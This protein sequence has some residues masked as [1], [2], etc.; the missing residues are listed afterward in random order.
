MGKSGKEMLYFTWQI[1]KIAKNT[2]WKHSE[3]HP[4]LRRLIEKKNKNH[5]AGVHNLQEAQLPSY[6]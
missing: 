2:A 6:N 5:V 4:L 3:I 1:L